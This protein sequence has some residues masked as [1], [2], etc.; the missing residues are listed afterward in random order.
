MPAT[1]VLRRRRFHDRRR[2]GRPRPVQFLVAWG[3]VPPGAGSLTLPRRS[4]T[5]FPGDTMTLRPCARPLRISGL[6]VLLAGVALGTACGPD[7][8]R[9]PSADDT[10]DRRE[11]ALTTFV[12]QL[13]TY[14]AIFVQS[15][16]S[17]TLSGLG[18]SPSSL[19]N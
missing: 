12:S 4:L 14:G 18:M 10:L 15:S 13:P 17:A 16:D 5:P 9:E 7:P 6:L 8:S 1:A 11:S 19:Q 2:W 3:G